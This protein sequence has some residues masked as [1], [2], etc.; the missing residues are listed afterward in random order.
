MPRE[1]RPRKTRQRYTDLSLDEGRDDEEEPGPS[2]PR[3][4]VQ[5]D[6][7]GDS[8]FAPPAPEEIAPSDED[9][10]DSQGAGLASDYV[11]E[12]DLPAQRSKKKRSAGPSKNTAKTKAKGKGKATGKGKENKAKRTTLVPAAPA[13]QV[14]ALPNLNVHHRHRPIPLFRPAAATPDSAAA[15]RVERLL[16]APRLFAPNELVPTLAYASSPALTRRVGK[17]WGL[18]VGAGPVWPIV[19]DLGWFRESTAK[20]EVE[21]AEGGGKGAK[22]LLYAERVRRPRVHARI[23][24]PRGGEGGR[25]PFPLLRAE[26]GI[27]YLPTQC[28]ADHPDAPAPAA[29]PVSCDFGPFGGQTNVKLETLRARKLSQFLPESHAHVFN[30][31]ASVWGLDWCPIHPDDRPHCAYKYYLAVAPFPSRTH[32]PGVGVKVARPSRACM[33]LWSLGPSQGTERSDDDKGEMRCEMVLCI[34]SGPAFELKWCPL[35]SHDPVCSIPTGS[36]EVSKL[37]MKWFKVVG[38]VSQL[39]KETRCRAGKRYLVSIFCHITRRLKPSQALL[40]STISV[41]QCDLPLSSAVRALT[42][43]RIPDRHGNGPTVIASGGYD[44]AIDSIAFSPYLS[45]VVTI[46]H[47]NTIKSYS[48]SPSTLGRGHALMDPRTG[49]DG[50]CYTT[51]GLRATRRGGYVPF[52]VHR[53]YQLDYSRTADSYRM[54]DR[55]KPRE[56]AERPEGGG[57]A[58]PASVG[59]QRV[60]WHCGAGLAAA[61]L[62]ASATGSGLCRVDWLEGRWFRDRVPYERV[63]AVRMEED[64]MDLDEPEDNDDSG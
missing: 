58:W 49:L 14:H 22:V 13:R 56:M 30:A 1:L 45:A 53:V 62:L 46:D 64:C 31:G 54:V 28:A 35:P 32:S 59:V 9:D 15:L 2:Q 44:D 37:M 17:A 47:E 42:W 16:H 5:E 63:E 11:S 7:G 6:R 60:A 24:A 27:A 57:G 33:Q 21:E 26:D 10:T 61:G 41:E 38:A 52:L 43:V 36:P 50:T 40:L 51:N 8:D 34:D 23:E 19:E 25:D 29:P 18:T 20:K 3:S 55:F 4:T 48:V 39:S 12:G